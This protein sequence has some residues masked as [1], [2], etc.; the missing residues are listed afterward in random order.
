MNR[1]AFRTVVK[2]A[3]TYDGRVL[4]GQKEDADDHPIGGEWHLL[5]GHLAFDESVEAATR[6]EVR[7][8]T[9]LDVTVESLVDAM[10]FAWGPDDAKNS[11]QILYHC[12]ASSPDAVAADDL[13]AVRWV[14][15]APEELTAHLTAEEAQ[16]VR[17]RPRQRA[18][19]ER[20]ADR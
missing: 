15:P 14:D 1:D 5:G 3:I 16:R 10:T 18:F 6:R 12:R 7:E 8:E 2:A 9:G 11:L 13:Q 17:S 4:I 19:F 20:L